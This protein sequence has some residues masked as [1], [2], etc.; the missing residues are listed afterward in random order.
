MVDQVKDEKIKE[1]KNTANWFP[2]QVTCFL[3]CLIDEM[4][5]PNKT[6]CD[7]G[8]K[9]QGW[10]SIHKAFNSKTVN[11]TQNSYSQAQLISK[12]SSQKKE[13]KVFCKMKELS[14]IGWNNEKEI[15]VMDKSVWKD[16]VA[17]NKDAGKYEHKTLDNF[18]LLNKIFIGKVAKGELSSSSTSASSTPSV[19]QQKINKPKS[20]P[21]DLLPKDD[22]MSDYSVDSKNSNNKSKRVK[23]DSAIHDTNRILEGIASNA[24]DRANKPSYLNSAMNIF[25]LEFIHL[26][27]RE[28]YTL[29]GFFKDPSVAEYFVHLKKVER[30][31]WVED[32]LKK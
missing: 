24:N 12:Y 32:E 8:F 26:S 15:P 16:Y 29:K 3:E 18:D 27:A 5:G 25:D 20:I 11:G 19:D 23:K 2:E 13:Y 7:T 4:N 17:N 6:F 21:K 9:G 10:T 22:D 31:F 1:E 30:E 14:G 28:K